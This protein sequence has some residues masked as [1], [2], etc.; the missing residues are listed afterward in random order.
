[1]GETAA[2]SQD[3]GGRRRRSNR[4][5]NSQAKGPCAQALWRAGAAASHR[6]GPRPSLGGCGKLSGPVQRGQDRARRW[7]GLMRTRG[8]CPVREPR[9]T[10]LHDPHRELGARLVPFAGWEMPVQYP[11]GILAEHQHCRSAAALFDV[12]HM[13]QVRVAGAEAA[14]RF[15]RLVPGNIQGLKPGQ[16]RYTLLTT[17]EGGFLDD[18]IVSNAGD[19]RFVV[20]NAGG[21]EADLAHMRA[22]L[23]PEL[24]VRELADRALLALQGPAAAAV[25]AVLAPES[26]GLSFM[27]TGEMSVGGLPCR[28]S[29]LG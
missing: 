9:R 29:R 24:E 13:G 4:P 22:G 25:M 19:H 17:D 23:E 6:R 10:P 1:M 3:G 21:R 7:G 2:P 26:A 28:V 11:A 8:P 20:V 14:A 27:S 12:S 5:G 16:G 18:L 15:E